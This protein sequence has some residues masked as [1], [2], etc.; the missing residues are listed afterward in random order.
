LRNFVFNIPQSKE[1][2]I[3]FH[4]FAFSPEVKP[5]GEFE[6]VFYVGAVKHVYKLEVAKQYIKSEK[7]YFYPGTQ[8]AIIF[9]RY[10]DDNTNTSV[11]E[12]GTKLSISK[13]AK[14]EISLKT[15]KNSSVFAAYS[16]VNISKMELDHVYNW[17]LDQF[18]SPIDPYTSLTDYSDKHVKSDSEIKNQALK[19]IEKADFNITDIKFRDSFEKLPEHLLNDLDSAPISDEEK[20]AI[21]KEKGFHYAETIFEHSVVRDGISEKYVLTADR[22]SKGT[23]RYYG[24]SAPFYNT[25]KHN[26]FLSID[27]I[28]ASLH[29]LLVKHFVKEFLLQANSSQLLITTHNMSLL[30]EKDILRKDAIWFTDKKEDGATDLYS[31]ADFADF[32]K[33]LSYFNYYKSG[34]FGAVPNID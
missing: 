34:K 8:P 23:V 12:F 2:E 21:R 22:Q 1:V 19:F 7:L 4:P 20:D 6:L 26:A 24:L 33:E 27:E 11:I 18:M 28:G 5:V 13:A 9:E 10:Y 30:N 25:I 14:E 3:E 32:R 15:L 17:F 29:P 16:Q 31:A